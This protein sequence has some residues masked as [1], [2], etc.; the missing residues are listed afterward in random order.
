M[1]RKQGP[2]V[3]RQ[4]ALLRSVGQA[5]DEVHGV[6]VVFEDHAP[7]EPPHLHMVEGPRGR[8]VSS[9]PPEHLPPDA[10]NIL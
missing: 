9:M 4:G 8:V 10:A 3:Q 6:G 7:L 1:V 2:G 5:T